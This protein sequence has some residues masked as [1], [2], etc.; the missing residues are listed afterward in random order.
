MRNTLYIANGMRFSRLVA[1]SQF[2][3]LHNHNHVIGI[4]GASL[5]RFVSSEQ[6]KVDDLIKMIKE[7][8]KAELKK[9][10]EDAKQQLIKKP[11]LYIR[12]IN[13]LSNPKQLALDFWHELKHYYHG[14]RLFFLD[15]KLSAKYIWKMVRRKK[16]L[17]RRERKQLVR[18]SSDL[19]RIIPFGFFIIVPCMEML[20][21]FYIKFFPQMMPSTFQ[22][23]SDEEKK[24][25]G[26][27]ET[28]KFLQDTFEEV[29]L[30]KKNRGKHTDSETDEITSKA[31]EFS[32]FMRKVRTEDEGY[33]SNAELFKFIKLF[34]DELTLDN[35]T[36]VQLRALC[37][38]L[39]ISKMGSPE[40][41]RIRLDMKLR[42]LKA[43]DKLIVAEG[44]V[45]VL[46]V[47]ELQAAC[48]A[49]G[50]RALGLSEER[51]KNQLKQW[52]ELSLDDQVPPSLLL[53]SRAMYFPEELTFT[54]RL[55]SI[56]AQLPEEVSEYTTLKLKEME[57]LADPKDR[58]EV[59]R[60]IEDD[61]K[62]EAEKIKEE[63]IPSKTAE[64]GNLLDQ[65]ELEK[66]EST[67]KELDEIIAKVQSRHDEEIR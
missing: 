18:T 12:I 9:K 22:T 41:L 37:R 14:F 62:Q 67:V 42:E 31:H 19:I 33:L 28:A 51:L 8:L 23:A 47:Q 60:S 2:P 15:L 38:L 10:D 34:E 45:D 26:K 46:S 1:G 50:M 7:N 48:R 29:A 56:I 52:L 49:R 61:L 21:P 35:L 54:H 55:R 6:K 5:V 24:H 36:I 43:D 40:F 59:L 57:G 13:K 4:G 53:L 44:G 66:V 17:Q 30:A 3:L 39:G 27:V 58:M 64:A 16:P 32:Q 63:P 65:N 11:P 25:K 20:L